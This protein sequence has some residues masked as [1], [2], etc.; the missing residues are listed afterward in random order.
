MRTG[1]SLEVNIAGVGG[2]TEMP[3]VH[4]RAGVVVL[5]VKAISIKT[6]VPNEDV[7]VLSGKRD[8]GDLRGAIESTLGGVDGGIVGG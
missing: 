8:S 7:E 3:G 2:A 6:E 5:A 4:L 1:S